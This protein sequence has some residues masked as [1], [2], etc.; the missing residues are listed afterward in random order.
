MDTPTTTEPLDSLLH[1]ERLEDLLDAWESSR[2]LGE[3]FDFGILDSAEPGLAEAFR[4]AVNDLRRFEALGADQSDSDEEISPKRI[5]PYPV[6]KRLAEGGSSVVYACRQRITNRMVAVKLLSP[7]SVSVRRIRRFRI[8]AELLATLTH[9]GIVQIYD[10]G[11]VHLGVVPQPYI[12]ME[13]VRGECLNSSLPSGDPTDAG[14]VR[15]ILGLFIQIADALSFAHLHGIIHRDLKPSNILIDENGRPKIIDFGIAHLHSPE[16]A[17]DQA[18]SFTRSAVGTPPYMSPEQFQDDPGLIDVRSDVYSLAVVLFKTLTGKLPYDLECRPYVE[19]ARIIRETAPLSLRRLDRRF[20]RSLDTVLEMALAKDPSERYQSASEFAAELHRIMLGQPIRASRVG[21]MRQLWMWGLRNPRTAAISGFVVVLLAIS[22]VVSGMSAVVAASR[23]RALQESLVELGREQA[24]T[25]QLT[26]DLSQR[27]TDLQRT[28]ERLIESADLQQRTAVNATLLRVGTLVDSDPT[29]ARSLLFDIT[30]CPPHLRGVAW[31]LLERQTR[32]EVI[33]FQASA[34]HVVSLGFAEEGSMLV[35]ASPG[36]VCW[37][38]VRDGSLVHSLKDGVGLLSRLAVNSLGDHAVVLRQDGVVFVASPSAGL[39]KRIHEAKPT[40]ATAVACAP[41]GRFFAVGD[42]TG[43]VKLWDANL[44]APMNDWKLDDSPIIVLNF[45]GD[46]K[47]CAAISRNGVVGVR[48][49]RG[50]SDV[51]LGR[52]PEIE[53]IGGAFNSDLKL[54]SGVARNRIVVWNRVES[55]IVSTEVDAQLAIWTAADPPDLFTATR[56]HLHRVRSGGSR[57]LFHAH[58]S[59]VRSLATARNSSRIAMGRADGKVTILGI[60]PSTEPS[61]LS[62][63]PKNPYLARYSRDGL[64]L[65]VAGKEADSTHSVR[66]FRL[67]EATVAKEYLGFTTQVDDVALSSDGRTLVVSKRYGPAKVEVHDLESPEP[68]RTIESP[69]DRITSLALSGDGRRLY[70]GE[71]TTGA[72]L[73]YDVAFGDL[74]KRLEG[75]MKNC[76]AVQLFQNDQR[77]LSAHAGGEI[78]CWNTRTLELDWK[79]HSGIQSIR[80]MTLSLDEQLLAVAHQRGSSTVW[81]MKDAGIEQLTTLRSDSSRMTSLAFSPDGTTLTAGD[82]SGQFQIW[83][84]ATWQPQLAWSNPDRSVNCVRFS[85][86]G[87]FL[88]ACSQNGLIHWNI[89]R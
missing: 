79:I 17:L 41:D 68:A 72:V 48:D 80:E 51:E 75:S 31:N 73:V 28:N 50:L 69:G 22:A 81:R 53:V 11:I 35:T 21:P 78:C 47:R 57:S 74:L 43:V 77:L 64:L 33:E 14:R 56:S 49:S 83:D 67:P 18:G 66:V 60:S 65:V 4:R 70:A 16:T 63:L 32:R 7:E 26:V 6:E 71:R 34:S 40:R 5:G 30:V 24:K 54:V 87:R 12:C 23:S 85:P 58:D 89:V 86:D 38:N 59:Q 3:E 8:E 88:T 39:K 37:W 62:P 20:D 76:R 9:P 46:G 1:N 45:S 13:L 52:F 61:K 29:L 27:N 2:E 42:E 10:A 25:T 44:E 84:T 15:H 55:R 36:L 82:Q 19:T